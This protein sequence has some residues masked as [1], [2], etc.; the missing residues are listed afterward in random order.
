M[1]NK[2]EEG[3]AVIIWKQAIR[4]LKSPLTPQSEQEDKESDLHR[5]GTISEHPPCMVLIVWSDTHNSS[6]HSA[7]SFRNKERLYI[8]I[9]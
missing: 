9:N 4:L 1:L 2:A 8:Y 7:S 3:K 6:R 5:T